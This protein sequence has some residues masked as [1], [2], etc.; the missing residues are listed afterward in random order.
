MYLGSIGILHRMHC[1]TTQKEHQISLLCAF[2][3]IF[4][5]SLYITYNLP[6]FKTQIYAEEITKLGYVL[7]KREEAR[8]FLDFYE[9]F[10]NTIEERVRDIPEEK[11][12]KISLAT[13]L[14]SLR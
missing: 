6:L 1:R 10:M 3:L 14:I 11:R 12:P 13:F 5:F 8:E 9:G 7:G 4:C 2:V